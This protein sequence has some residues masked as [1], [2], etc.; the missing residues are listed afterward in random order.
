MPELPELPKTPARSEDRLLQPH[1]N[2]LIALLLLNHADSRVL[3]YHCTT[4]QRASL[5]LPFSIH[6]TCE[7]AP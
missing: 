4:V 6:I 5:Q 3:V 7:T 2:Y 1:T